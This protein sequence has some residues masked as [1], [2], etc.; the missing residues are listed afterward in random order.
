MQEN[1][2]RSFSNQTPWQTWAAVLGLIFLF[3]ACVYSIFIVKQSVWEPRIIDLDL[4]YYLPWYFWLVLFTGAFA[5]LL[6]IQFSDSELLTTLSLIGITILIAPGFLL[7]IYPSV[8]GWDT[9]L[10]TAP[11]KFILENNYLPEK[12]HYANQYP[13]VIILNALLSGLGGYSPITTSVIIT[14]LI[15]ITLVIVF[16]G[17]LSNFL[18]HKQAAYTA[19]AVLSLSPAI[20]TNDHFSQ[21]FVSYLLFWG[22]LLLTINFSAPQTRNW[23]SLIIFIN[24]LFAAIA[25][26]HP[27]LP[28][29]SLI[30]TLGT[31]FI[32]WRVKSS[33]LKTNTWII[34][35]MVIVIISW[36]IF[37]ADL[38]FETGVFGIKEFFIHSEETISSWVAISPAYIWNHA[39]TEALAL[40][41][42]R[43]TCYASIGVI[44]IA[45]LFLPNVDK[46]KLLVPIIL[47]VVSLL[48]VPVSIASEAPWIQRWIY[49]AP[50]LLVIGAGI[51]LYSHSQ[52]TL[53]LPKFFSLAQP[54]IFALFTVLGFLLWHPPSLVYSLHPAEA[55]FFIWPQEEQA[56]S[57]LAD[58]SSQ[59][60]NVHS[61]IETM[62]VYNYFAPEINPFNNQVSMGHDL[63]DL[64]TQSPLLFNGRWI[65]RS[66]RQEMISYQAQDKEEDFWMDLDDK[67]ISETSRIYDNGFVVIYFNP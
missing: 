34:V 30:F 36:N 18:P 58:A 24:L 27:F 54:A 13:G 35:L 29:V 6:T 60:P 19:V 32:L 2:Q 67:L 1:H 31:S 16:N 46:R 21:F 3:S 22:I 64:I 37:I 15:E 39:S 53:R 63:D 44:T 47:T 10:H 49:F 41:L 17:F 26:T 42:I 56:M 25:T 14:I 23:S 50:P 59:S 57:Y 66:L 38:Y 12:N 52:F 45:G 5:G 20:I 33:F 11:V 61:D 43:L 9:Y 65:V 7:A 51:V 28:I 55:S 40:I 62:L 48:I 4:T 8:S